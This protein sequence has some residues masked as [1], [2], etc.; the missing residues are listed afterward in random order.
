MTSLL[1]NNISSANS[2]LYKTLGSLIKAYRQ[3]K[4]IS[5][6]TLSSTIGISVRELQNWESDRRRARIENIHDLAEVT[7]IPMQVC[8]ALN[9]D[10]PIWYSLQKRRFAYSSLEAQYFHKEFFR[11]QEISGNKTFARGKLIT[12]DKQIRKILTCHRELYRA[13]NILDGDIIKEAIALL[14]DVNLI[15]ID[16]AGHYMG[17]N[18]FLPLKKEVYQ[19]LLQQEDFE[20]FLTPKSLSDII[21]LREGVF[22]N[23]STFVGSLNVAH[24]LAIDATRFLVKVEQKNRYVIAAFVVPAEGK[25]FFTNMGMRNVELCAPMQT[26]SAPSMYEIEMDRIMNPRGPLSALQLVLNKQGWKKDPESRSDTTDEGASKFDPSS[27]FPN[28]PL[29]TDEPLEAGTLLMI[30]ESLDFRQSLCKSRD[31][32]EEKDRIMARA[33]LNSACSLYSKTSMGNIV[34]NGM[35]QT[36]EGSIVQGFLCKACGKSFCSRSRS[37]YYGLRSSEA[38]IR[39]A[40]DL[41]AKGMSLRGVGRTLGV[42]PDTVRRWLNAAVENNGQPLPEK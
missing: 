18:I 23:Y 17:H 12:T 42:K 6:E 7:G 31:N 10:Q 29:G 32:Q 36:K 27:G 3:W 19:L 8:V 30:K 28:E 26:E 37:I 38:K 22:F 4:D 16:S 11:Y 15:Y 25:E 1:R 2:V 13:K 9:A 14:P 24:Q 39:Q 34:Y 33:C 40:L 21:T 5:Q 35:R 20:L 41:L